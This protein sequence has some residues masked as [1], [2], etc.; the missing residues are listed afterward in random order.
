MGRMRI[1]LTLLLSMAS[2]MVGTAQPTVG[3][4]ARPAPTPA[5]LDIEDI[6]KGTVPIDGEWQFH[7]GDDV[8]WASPSYDDSQ[9]EHIKTDTSW[10][11]QTHP[12]YS[13]FA[14]YR[15]HLDIA[16]SRVADEKLAIL[17]PAVEDEY[18]V[19]WNG[20]EIGSQG[21]LP[22][23]AVWYTAHRQSF[24][25]PVSPAGVTDG[26]LA[27]RVWKAKLASF[28]YSTLGGMKG[29]PVLGDAESITRRISSDDFAS[30][31][32]NLYFRIVTIIIALMGMVALFTWAHDRK[33]GV[34]LWF[35]IWSVGRVAQFL[36]TMP[37]INF[38][39][40]RAEINCVLQLIFS[41]HNC[42]ALLLLF[43]LFDLQDNTSLRRWTWWVVG[44][45]LSAA[46]AD[47]LVML[48]WAHAGH[49][50]QWADALLSFV[51]VL[52]RLFGFVLAY[53]GLKRRMNPEFKLVAVI[54]F[55]DNL[56]EILRFSSRQ[57]VRFT[58][59]TLGTRLS[60]PLFNV[61]D[62]GIT[63]LVILDTILLIAVVYA[64][65]R[66]LARESRRQACIEQEL[67]SA[68]EVQQV[69]IPEAPPNIPG[70]AIA[71]VY[72]PAHEV[73]GDFFQ[74]IPMQDG[75]TLVILGDV[76]GK[77]L[78]AAMNVALIVGTVRT[79]AEFQSD[80]AS[81]LAGLNHRLVGRMQGGFTTALAFRIDRLGHC[82]FANAGHVPPF[83]NGNEM[84]LDPSLPLGIDP[85]AEY[86]D[87]DLMLNGGDR[88]M[89][90]TDGVLEARSGK[91]ELYG[92]DRLKALLAGVPDAESIVDAALAFGQ[93]DDITV[94]TIERL[95]LNEAA[96][97]MTVNFLVDLAPA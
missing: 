44:V 70:Y 37:S 23:H 87:Q 55:L 80:P 47:G 72:Y 13:G 68:R 73:G 59:W 9:W 14:W 40:S 11:A 92:F 63:A 28:D 74:I 71:S 89:L 4:E 91:G 35:G 76:S 61:A 67:K 86:R 56:M 53:E 81:I 49:S 83:L 10:G 33:Q 50:M 57:G 43:Y 36:T 32:R 78:K 39:F 34:F 94:V 90:H 93:E 88:L 52:C 60:T 82:T 16:P 65:L 7:L 48:F 24:A 27:V 2:P 20:V 42:A 21:T 41:I 30:M 25:F 77:G 1:L 19:Y 64:L 31:R 29:P 58:H 51:I 46:C 8:R 62:A 95:R 79:L 5:V 97:S 15:R 84:S 96:A 17:M 54:A 22:P 69:L 45:Q 38:L 26:V 18:D 66:Y 85:E 12:S 75:A 6:G 3:V